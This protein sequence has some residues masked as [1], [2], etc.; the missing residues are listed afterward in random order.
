MTEP[1]RISVLLSGGGT[2]LQALIDQVHLQPGGGVIVSAISNREAF[3][4][5]RA[6][7]AGIATATVEPTAAEARQNYDLR[8]QQVVK[9]ST[10]DLVVLAGFMRI[11]SPTF[12]AGFEGRVLN[13]H[14]SLLP[15][16]KGLHTHQ[17]VIDAGETWHGTS[18]HFVS[19]E[20]DGGP[21]IAQARL[22][23]TPGTGAEALSDEVQLLEHILYPR[24]VRWFCCGRLYCEGG[25]VTL[26]GQPLEKGI[27]YDAEELRQDAET[28]QPAG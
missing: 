26:D 1:C 28:N 12:L 24:I 16:Y 3:G 6:E 15:E 18:V 23:V 11:L 8:L 21:L 25:R 7:R 9:E 14:P 10:P 13:I 20:L 17:R 19:K 2:N 5:T 27:C 22:R 4:L